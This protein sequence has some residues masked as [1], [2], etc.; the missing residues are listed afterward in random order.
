MRSRG[1]A[2]SRPPRSA[3]SAYSSS[4]SWSGRAM[5]RCKSLRTSMETSRALAIVTARRSDVIRRSLRRPPRR[6]VTTSDVNAWRPRPSRSRARPAI[7]MPGRS[8]SWYDKGFF[9]L[10]VNARLQVEHPVTE[11]VW[12]VDLVEQQLSVA[13]GER[14]DLRT[15]RH[16]RQHAVEAR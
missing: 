7:G 8:S 2:A 16:G 9:F 10:E 11:L 5:S 4:G 15:E 1:R 6:L 14:L 12:G 3:T 13:M